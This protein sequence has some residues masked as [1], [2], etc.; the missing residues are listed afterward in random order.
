[1]KK[2]P[3][4]ISVIIVPLLLVLVTAFSM[5]GCKKESDEEYDVVFYWTPSQSSTQQGPMTETYTFHCLDNSTPGC[6]TFSFQD[7]PHDSGNWMSYPEDGSN[8]LDFI[9]V[10]NGS[11]GA[12]F[13]FIGTLVA[14]MEEGK[15][16]ATGT[17]DKELDGS[18]V[19]IGIFTAASDNISG[20]ISPVCP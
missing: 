15:I 4:L 5:Q 10:V 3:Y 18:T 6:N 17:Y 9:A 14:P 20:D 7:E 19:E 16:R 8:C 2:S 11:D 1:M 13:T 12:V